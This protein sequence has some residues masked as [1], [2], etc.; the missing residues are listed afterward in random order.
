MLEMLRRFE[1]EEAEPLEDMIEDD[2]GQGLAQRLAGIDLGEFNRKRHSIDRHR[3]RQHAHAR[4]GFIGYRLLAPAVKGLLRPSLPIR[5][6]KKLKA[7]IKQTMSICRTY[8]SFLF[9]SPY[10]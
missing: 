1:E 6:L 4:F 2:G 5:L 8:L 3:R 7:T 10:L 9:I